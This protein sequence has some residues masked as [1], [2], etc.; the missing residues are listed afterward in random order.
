MQEAA[1]RAIVHE[2]AM[3]LEAFPWRSIKPDEAIVANLTLFKQTQNKRQNN[4]EKQDQFIVRR[5]P[6][7]TG[8]VADTPARATGTTLNGCFVYYGMPE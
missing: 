3:A 2:L 6:S 4:C 5:I 1:A 7:G 8:Q